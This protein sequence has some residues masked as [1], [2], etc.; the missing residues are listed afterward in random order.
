MEIPAMELEQNGVRLWLTYLPAI[1]LLDS[2]RVKVDVYSAAA[3]HTGYQRLPTPARAKDYARYLKDGKGI[4]PNT[5]LINLR[6]E[7]GNFQRISGPYGKLIVPDS[8]KLWIV[9]GQHR[10]EGLRYLLENNPTFA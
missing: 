5:V 8:T 10:I 7:V 9:D 6:G 3:G 2:E 1:R 4:S